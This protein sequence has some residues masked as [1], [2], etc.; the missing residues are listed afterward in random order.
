MYIKRIYQQ[1]R[2]AK[3]R[4]NSI[5]RLKNCAFVLFPHKNLFI[6]KFF[7]EYFRMA[8]VWF[9]VAN[10]FFFFFI[11]AKAQKTCLSRGAPLNPEIF[12]YNTCAL[13]YVY[14]PQKIFRHIDGKL[15]SSKWFPIGREIQ[16]IVKLRQR[17][18]NKTTVSL[19]G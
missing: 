9:V 1:E 18:T 12:N 6:L 15:F 19:L 7:F 3:I 16:P 13:C 17:S 2:K 5:L 4:K 10:V 8:K 11:G 14:M